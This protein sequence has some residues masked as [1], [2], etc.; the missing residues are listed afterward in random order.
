[1]KNNNDKKI[2]SDRKSKRRHSLEYRSKDK[3]S[4]DFDKKIENI[5]KK[6]FKKKLK[7]IEDEEIWEEW[8]DEYNI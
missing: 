6:Q 4:L 2:D 5:H 7:E 3:D 8:K 1:M